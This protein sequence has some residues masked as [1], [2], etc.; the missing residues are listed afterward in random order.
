VT[1]KND[2]SS[3]RIR[4]RVR[5]SVV[6]S[7]YVFA[8]VLFPARTEWLNSKI[9]GIFG[10]PDAAASV[11]KDDLHARLARLDVAGGGDPERLRRVYAVSELTLDAVF[12]LLYAALFFF[13]LRDAWPEPADRHLALL[14]RWGTL[15]LPVAAALADWVENVGF[16]KAATL[17]EWHVLQ[18]FRQAAVVE[19]LEPLVAWI[20]PAHA[21]KLGL[22]K[23]MLVLV[24]LG[25]VKSGV[26]GR[27]MSLVWLG[28][29][30]L[31]AFA[32]LIALAR[33]AGADQ[34]S[35]TIPSMAVLKTPLELAAVTLLAGLA[36]VLAGFSL[37]LVWRHGEART[38]T[39]LP[40]VPEWLDVPTRV[41]VVYS[42]LLPLPLVALCGI[43]GHL[44]GGMSVLEVAAGFAL[45]LM[46]LVGTAAL[47]L[48]LGRARVAGSEGHVMP[49]LLRHVDAAGYQDEE[50][51]VFSGHRLAGMGSLVAVLLYLA[52]FFALDPERGRSAAFPALAYV[53]FLVALATSFLSGA[54]FF[55]DRYRAPLLLVLLSWAVA[56]NFISPVD[57]V[58]HWRRSR[59]S[60]PAAAAALSA[61]ASRSAGDVLTVVTASGG[62][63]QAAAWTARVL[64]G[65]DE[66]FPGVFTRSVGVVSA[67]SGGSVGTYFFLGGLDDSGAL[68]PAFRPSVVQ[69][70]TASSLE[71][72]AWGIL[73]P[74][75]QRALLPGVS[76]VRD[77]AWAMERRWLRARRTLQPLEALDAEDRDGEWLAS[78]VRGAAS[79]QLPAVILNATRIDNGEPLR[80]STVR[81]GSDYGFV[82]APSGDAYLDMPTV[83]ATRLSA[84]FPYVTPIGRYARNPVRDRRDLPPLPE[85]VECRFQRWHAGDGG[86]F[87]NHGTVAALD[88]LRDVE[89]TDPAVV[90]RFKSVV[91]LQIDSF[92]MAGTA[93]EAAEGGG[94]TL[95]AFGPI[96][97]LLNV[98]TA[99]QE[100]RRSVEADL[101]RA[102]LP[103][104]L[105][106][107]T[108]RPPYVPGRRDP[109]L[110][111]KLT[112]ADVR[113]VED[114]WSVSAVT[115]PAFDCMK[116]LFA[117]NGTAKDCAAVD[118]R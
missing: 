83:T 56:L 91:W 31:L 87:D 44:L 46:V 84:T 104:K 2:V 99:S 13:A 40:D 18:P 69:A 8:L 82:T 110:S 35:T 73:Y 72:A 7:A 15:V 16:W 41:R 9:D 85:C 114:A 96:Q 47:V 86:Y 33:L 58:F 21:L 11:S 71:E 107:V 12:P 80:L 68:P 34:V 17:P 100:V 112:D 74:D 118:P 111:W 23:V 75:L 20:S 65:L 92:P 98:R 106:V 10:P 59:E 66:A 70:A 19:A 27:W 77:R 5:G 49:W 109:P 4:R 61:R 28:R 113:R 1:V 93:P 62:G 39:A 76:R 36:A 42:L 38:G 103:E 22:V 32:L 53:L 24:L 45:G 95:A 25:V 57:H 101:L 117:G 60:R 55:L 26:L 3:R 48:T 29:V 52:G 108:F 67:V 97:G 81:F 14:R 78:W 79:G 51:N 116:R 54:A 37:S 115:S 63:I 6:L 64:T 50:G 94:W 90:D 43:R 102:H 30:P 89:R 105:A 88:W